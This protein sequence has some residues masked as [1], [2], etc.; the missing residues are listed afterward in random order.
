MQDPF[1][2]TGIRLLL[3]GKHDIFLIELKMTQ[4]MASTYVSE[5]VKTQ[6]VIE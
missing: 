5:N 3:Q 6:S 1:K 2:E 4:L